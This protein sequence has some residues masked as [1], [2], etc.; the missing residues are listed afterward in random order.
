MSCSRVIDTSAATED[1]EAMGYRDRQE[2]G[3][4]LVGWKG[5]GGEDA[6]VLA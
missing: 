6:S 2:Q 1:D 5:V 4:Q 3:P